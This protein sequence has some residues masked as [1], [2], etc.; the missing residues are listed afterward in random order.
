MVL[1]YRFRAQYNKKSSCII[2]YTYIHYCLNIAITFNENLYH[3]QWFAHYCQVNRMGTILCSTNVR[4]S[5][6]PFW[7]T[8]TSVELNIHCSVELSNHHTASVVLSVFLGPHCPCNI[9]WVGDYHPV[10]KKRA[11]LTSQST[12]TH[13]NQCRYHHHKVYMAPY[14]SLQYAWSSLILLDPICCVRVVM[15]AVSPWSH[16]SALPFFCVPLQ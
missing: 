5:N 6:H 12:D 8:F 10:C 16:L 4:Q 13:N 2:K 3:F 14:N 7:N 1:V 9:W 11:T 15:Q